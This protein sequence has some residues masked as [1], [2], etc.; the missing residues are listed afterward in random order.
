MASYVH[1][2][3]RA[4]LQQRLGFLALG[5]TSGRVT[6]SLAKTDL[7][8]AGVDAFVQATVAIGINN[9]GTGAVPSNVPVA[10]G[11]YRT[12]D[13]NELGTFVVLSF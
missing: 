7:Y 2:G 1:D 12:G 5:E 11:T 8:F 9:A 6:K 4:A 10:S 13:G 3:D